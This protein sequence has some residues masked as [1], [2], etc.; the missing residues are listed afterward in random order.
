MKVLVIFKH[1]FYD[2]D[3][4]TEFEL[5]SAKMFIV[6]ELSELEPAFDFYCYKQHK[7]WGEPN[8]R[9]IMI[10]YVMQNKNKFIQ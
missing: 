5:K 1:Y 7:L 10:K 4:E 3:E 9:P 6:D 2:A 8:G